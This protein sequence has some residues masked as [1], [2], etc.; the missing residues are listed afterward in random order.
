MENTVAVEIELFCPNCT[1]SFAAAPE[2]RSEEIVQ[3]MTEDG[4][5]YALA[6]GQSFE[7]MVCSALLDRGAIRCP[8]CS[9]PV[10]VREKSMGFLID[11]L[12]IDEMTGEQF[13]HRGP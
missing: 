7:D 6:N 1:K 12:G 3:R 5:W 4:P 11:M 13:E 2:T 9:R 10:L 8:E